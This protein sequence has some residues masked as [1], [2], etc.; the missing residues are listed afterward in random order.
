MI[1]TDQ[2]KILDNKIRANRAQ[3]DLVR[4]NAE[5]SALSSSEIE[6][7]EYITGKD[8]EI[9]PSVVDKAKLEYS[10]LGRVFNEGLDKS[11]RKEGVLKRLKNIEEKTNIADNINNEVIKYSDSIVTKS[12][13]GNFIKDLTP[14]EK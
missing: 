1:V 7:Y 14:K 11:D 13:F 5:I 6:K 10:P 8:L 4:K 9:K 12:D 3:Y 2:L